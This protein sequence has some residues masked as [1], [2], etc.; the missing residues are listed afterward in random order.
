M[1]AINFKRALLA[2]GLLISLNGNAL[3]YTTQ[4]AG[5][6]SAPASW[7]GGLIPPAILPAGNTVNILHNITLTS[8][9]TISG[10]YNVSLVGGLSGN[11]KITIKNGGV[12]TNLGNINVTDKVTIDAG[13]TLTNT[14][15]FST[16][17][18]FL[19]N[20]TVTNSG[21]LSADK[22]END[23]NFTNSGTVNCEQEFENSGAV[24]NSGTINI[25]DEFKNEGG[26]VSGGGSIIVCEYIQE[27]PSSST[28]NQNI[29]CSNGG[30]PDLEV[31]DGVFDFPGTVTIC[32]T[33]LPV[34]LGN[35]EINMENSQVEILW[36]TIS[37]RNNE[38]F[39]IERSIDNLTWE[40]LTEVEAKGN[41]SEKTNYNVQDQN[42]LFGTSYYRLSQVD[43]DGELTILASNSFVSSF[44]EITIYPQPSNNILNITGE[45]LKNSSLQILNTQGEIVYI[46]EYLESNN[47]VLSATNFDNGIYFVKISNE[48]Q[49]VTKKIIISH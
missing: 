14:G 22:I 10:D 7:V 13:G 5:L 48:E 36:E 40:L 2:I 27:D 43:F 47:V 42:P 41:T 16:T 23:N 39:I 12:I 25:D 9:L 4:A 29:C 30:A 18:E 8:H 28:I 3:V 26:T 34:I 17:K 37:E 19:N 49:I 44:T 15:T 35:F 6:F 45:N 33:V 32:S 21:T 46:S 38:H 20:G 1:K 24:I 11:K 31:E